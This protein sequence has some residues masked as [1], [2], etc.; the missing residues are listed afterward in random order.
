MNYFNTLKTSKGFYLLVGT[1]KQAEV[2]QAEYE[3]ASGEKTELETFYMMGTQRLDTKDLT[4]F[5]A[6][7]L[8]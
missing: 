8:L 3:K 5:T 7:I 6:V 1:T 4:Q 2:K